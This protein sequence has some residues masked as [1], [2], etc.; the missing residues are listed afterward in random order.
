M[1]D[2]TSAASR[3]MKRTNVQRLY[4][5]SEEEDEEDCHSSSPQKE[6]SNLSSSLKLS[7]QIN[8][9]TY[10]SIPYLY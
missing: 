6:A 2:L 5:S 7:H 1:R 9:R 3:R 10:H 4:L 8:N